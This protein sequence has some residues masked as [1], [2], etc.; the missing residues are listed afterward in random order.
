MT[1]G[2]QE[3]VS[4]KPTG[5]QEHTS[6]ITPNNQTDIQAIATNNLGT[7]EARPLAPLYPSLTSLSNTGPPINEEE[8]INYYTLKGYENK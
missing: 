8:T 2:N 1:A 3:N 5:N 6:Q 4:M 7:S